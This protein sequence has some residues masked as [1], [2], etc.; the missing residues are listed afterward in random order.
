MRRDFCIISLQAVFRFALCFHCLVDI[1]VQQHLVLYALLCFNA[2]PS[3]QDSGMSPRGERLAD[4]LSVV[5][6]LWS[7]ILLIKLDSWF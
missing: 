5:H 7:I 6:E 3:L 1:S 4:V 2:V